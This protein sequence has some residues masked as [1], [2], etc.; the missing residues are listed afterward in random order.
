M[1]TLPETPSQLTGLV[2]ICNANTRLLV[3]G[4]F[5]GVRSLQM[6]QYY[7]HPQNQF[8]RILGL[9]WHM[10]LPA[11]PYAERCAAALQHGLGIWDVYAHCERQGSL[12]S[13]ICN[14]QVNDLAALRK[15]CPQLLA[16]AHNGG[17]SW[18]HRKHTAALGVAVHRLPSTSPAHASW[19]LER[20]FTA[21]REVFKPYGLCD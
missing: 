14:A 5:P 12:D 15:Q 7:A 10:D 6:Q 1:P 18:K 8:W 2:P 19:S 11:L 21:W 16:I 17:E 9:L 4:S 13:A 3:L 20:K